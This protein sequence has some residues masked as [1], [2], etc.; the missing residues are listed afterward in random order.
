MQLRALLD[1]SIAEFFG[2]SRAAQT[3]RAYPPV[4]GFGGVE[5][6]STAGVALEVGSAAVWSMGC[7]W[8]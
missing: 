4:S 5:L 7:G 3:L 2:N 6:S 8:A 1:R